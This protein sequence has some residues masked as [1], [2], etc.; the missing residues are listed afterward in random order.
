MKVKERLRDF[1][2]LMKT[3]ET[4]LNAMCYLDLHAFPFSTLLGQLMKLDW[5]PKN[6][7]MYHY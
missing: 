6:Q 5:G 2:R 4:Q 3:K 7:I 1:S